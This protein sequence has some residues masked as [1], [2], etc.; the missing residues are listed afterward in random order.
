MRVVLDAAEA[1]ELARHPLLLEQLRYSSST[2]F[3]PIPPTL[4]LSF[5]LRL[6]HDA[7]RTRWLK[8]EG[9]VRVD[10]DY[11]TGP[12]PVAMRE[13]KTEAEAREW[14]RAFAQAGHYRR[15]MLDQVVYG[16]LRWPERNGLMVEVVTDDA[17]ARLRHLLPNELLFDSRPDFAAQ[18]AVELAR[19][20][21]HE[22]RVAALDARPWL[23]RPEGAQT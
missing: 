18:L 3:E 9:Q 14:A 2:S 23:E 11:G 8:P 15:V 12:T 22:E 10:V 21:Y 4:G 6:L 17:H 1:A 5:L 19:R 13:A 16:A 7:P 20:L